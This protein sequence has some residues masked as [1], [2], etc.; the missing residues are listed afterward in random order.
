MPLLDIIGANATKRS[1][2][3]AFTFLS[4]ETKEDYTWAFKRLKTLYKQYSGV[5]L[6]VILTDRCLAVINAAS[7]LFLLA[8]S[9]YT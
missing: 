8:T 2:C 7:A 6:S 3:I 5:F 9:L 1:F 4:G